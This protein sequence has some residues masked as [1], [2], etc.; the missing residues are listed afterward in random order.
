RKTLCDSK[1]IEML[2]HSIRLLIHYL[3]FWDLPVPSRFIPP[4]S[5]AKLHANYRHQYI[6][7]IFSTK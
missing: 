5:N 6:Q 2:K 1:S 7:Y 3:K 4:L